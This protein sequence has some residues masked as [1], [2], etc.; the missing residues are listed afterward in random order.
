MIGPEPISSLA[1]TLQRLRANERDPEIVRW[2]RALTEAALAIPAPTNSDRPYTRSLIHKND[3]FEILV[4]HWK[5][6]AETLIHDHGGARCWFSVCSGTM[7][8]QNFLR[9]DSGATP[10]Y[11]R[12]RRDGDE[13]LNP[14][15]IDYRQDDVHLHRCIAGQPVTSLHIYAAPLVRFRTFEERSEHCCEAMSTYD[16]ILAAR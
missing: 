7:S 9:C 10:G 1:T 6:G 12:I 16:A 4:L 3:A 15:D 5:P 2:L 14:G 11:A 8:V 13:L